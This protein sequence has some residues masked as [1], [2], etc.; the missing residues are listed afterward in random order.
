MG[1][2]IP[3][4]QLEAVLEEAVA[5]AESASELPAKWLRR[6]AR[7]GDS[8]AQTYVAAWGTALLARAADERVDV[9]TVKQK[10][11]S[12]AYSMRGVVKIL[13]GQASHFGYH[14]GVTGPEPLNNQ[15]WFWVERVDEIRN[16]RHDVAPFHRDLV[17]YLSDLNH[18]SADEAKR[19][20]A[21]FIRLR[22]QHTRSLPSVSTSGRGNLP[23]GELAALI[24]GFIR[25]DP[26]NGRRGQSLVAAALDLANRDVR[27]A[28]I[29]DPTGLDVA[30]RVDG[31]IQLGVEVKQK[32][33]TESAAERLVGHANAGAFDK[34]LLVALATN[35]QALDRESVRRAADRSG[36]LA[37]IYESVAELLGETALHSSRTAAEF[38]AELPG[39]YLRRMAEHEVSPEG[40]RLFLDL[41]NARIS[42]RGH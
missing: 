28:P 32:P 27:L 31:S 6:A 38:A 30:V 21:A 11:S 26:E 23:L 10:A 42:A 7:M 15:P 12:R 2:T 9:L 1:I 37:M 35:Q 16:V 33:V 20:L 18:A 40:Q 8:P 4:Q 13:A 36:V 22:I 29:N 3:R 24:E 19:G 17:R 14:L 5:V 39:A 34:A 41:Y 25:A